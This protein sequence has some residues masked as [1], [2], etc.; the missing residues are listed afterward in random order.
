MTL[1]GRKNFYSTLLGCAG[2]LQIKLTKEKLARKKTFLFMYICM[3]EITE[4][5]D[6][7]GQ[8]EFG[9]YISS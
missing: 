2:A 9:A 5:C 4:K 8:L 7:K 1:L 3:Q 6:Q